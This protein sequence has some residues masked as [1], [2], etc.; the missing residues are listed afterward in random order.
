[1]TFYSYVHVS[2]NG[3]IGPMP[4]VTA[5]RD[6]CPSDCPL[7]G[8]GCYAENFPLGKRWDELDAAGLT[9]EQM[10]FKIKW[11]PPQTVWRYGQ[12]GDLPN[13]PAE[14]R[15]LAKANRGRRGIF[16]SHKR[17]FELYHEVAILGM[18]VNLSASSID[19]CDSLTQTGLPVVV[20]L[21]SEFGRRDHETI[22][23]YRKR[24][25][26]SISLRTPAGHKIAICPATY[27][28]TTCARCKVCASPRPGGV[29]IGFPAHGT[30]KKIVDGLIRSTAWTEK[31]SRRSLTSPKISPSS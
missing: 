16:Y 24:L 23:E 8:Q 21:P 26:G 25:G 19:E 14:V 2:R 13:D 7:M 30:K 6:T 28:D 12:A 9:F 18:H 22:P 3:K 29:I 1:M 20:V 11:L 5:S 15:T 4:C 10:V 17:D 27:S 31:S